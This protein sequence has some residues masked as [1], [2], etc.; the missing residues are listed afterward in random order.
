MECDLVGGSFIPEV[1]LAISLL[2]HLARSKSPMCIAKLAL[3]LHSSPDI[4]ASVC[5]EMLTRDYLR[6]VGDGKF[7]LGPSLARLAVDAQA[8]P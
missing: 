3:A 6:Q 4:V 7:H 8:L 5:Q 2:E 1:V